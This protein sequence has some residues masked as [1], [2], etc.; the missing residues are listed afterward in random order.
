MSTPSVCTLH[1]NHSRL[2]H[3]ELNVLKTSH[4][5]SNSV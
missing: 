5:C 4:H 2:S 3:N 1:Q